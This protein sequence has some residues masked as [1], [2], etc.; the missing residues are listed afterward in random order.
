M[1]YDNAVSVVFYVVSVPPTKEKF[2]SPTGKITMIR[3]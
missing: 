3:L 1:H 2:W